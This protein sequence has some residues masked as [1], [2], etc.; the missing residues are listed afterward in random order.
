MISVV[1][2]SKVSQTSVFE[3]K[4]TVS[5]S[6]HLHRINRLPAVIWLQTQTAVP[7]WS[8]IAKR[9]YKSWF[10]VAGTDRVVSQSAAVAHLQATDCEDEGGM[11]EGD[12]QRCS[13]GSWQAGAQGLLHQGDSRTPARQS[14][15]QQTAS[16]RGAVTEPTRLDVSSSCCSFCAR[17][18]ASARVAAASIHIP[19]SQLLLLLH[20][21]TFLSVSSCCC[22]IGTHFSESALVVIASVHIAL[23]QLLLHLKTL[24]S[25]SCRCCCIYIK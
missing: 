15:A 10:P 12:E 1:V 19:Q 13:C 8:E 22:C 21:Y 7:I 5:R 14:S 3:N 20:L 4:G 17:C 24:L 6:L 18:S 11:E 25:V 16:D 2:K 23:R 9:R